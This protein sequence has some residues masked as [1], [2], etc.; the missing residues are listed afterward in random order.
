MCI[1]DSF[2]SEEDFLS[3]IEFGHETI[4]DIVKLQE[5]L[6][7]ECGKTKREIPEIEVNQV[8]NVAVDKLIEGKISELNAPREKAE[9]YDGIRDF[10]QLIVDELSVEFP[11]DESAIKSYIEDKISLDLR[12]MTLKGTRADGR[13]F[14]TVRDLSL[15]HI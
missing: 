3:V 11:E 4:K 14:K 15:I 12:Q 1:R 6:V 9:R 10:K 13:D 2:I 5:E 8:L 7:A